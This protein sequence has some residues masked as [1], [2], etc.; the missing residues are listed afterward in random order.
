MRVADLK[1]KAA[2]D[3]V[4]QPRLPFVGRVSGKTKLVGIQGDYPPLTCRQ[5]VVEVVLSS[6]P[7]SIGAGVPHGGDLGL[8]H[9]H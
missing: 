8:N 4:W 7:Q 2:F 9:L 6:R 5:V 1:I 3:R